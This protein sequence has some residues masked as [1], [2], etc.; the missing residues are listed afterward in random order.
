MDAGTLPKPPVAWD[1]ELSAW[2]VTGYELV[3]QALRDTARFTSENGIMA[4]NLGEEAMLADDSPVHDAVRAVWARSFG[5]GEVMARRAEIE[6]LA[7]E[8]LSPVFAALRRGETVD[9]VPVLDAMA[10]RVVLGMLAFSEPREAEFT[11]LCKILLEGSAFTITPDHPLHRAKAEAKAQV[12]AFLEHEMRNRLDRVARGERPTDLI[13]LIAQAEGRSGITRAV[14]L[15]NLFNVFVGGGDTTVRWMGNAI[16]LLH[17]HP[18]AL[19]ELRA[20]PA[21]LPQ[22]LEEVMRIRSVTRFA[23]RAV[24]IDG[25]VL[26]GQAMPRGDTVYLMGSAANLDPTVFEDPERFDIHRRAKPH[27]GFSHG[28]HLCIG[29]NLARIEAQVLLGQL[30]L[31]PEAPRLAVVEADYGDQSVVRGPERLLLRMAEGA[32]SGAS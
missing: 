10:G 29:M 2:T 21:L 5:V 7:R 25:V 14:A 8:L 32:R 20:N 24:K 28:M 18:D 26:A 15:S 13:A 9:V 16:V 11:R 17:Q 4:A 23:I 31:D 6:Q 22:A 30:L 27:L 19:A 3:K 1:P 12:Y